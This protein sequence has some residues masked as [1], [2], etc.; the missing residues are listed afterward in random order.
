MRKKS[1]LVDFAAVIVA[2]LALLWLW[3]SMLSNLDGRFKKVNEDYDNGIAVNLSSD[4]D[5]DALSA[6]LQTNMYADNKKEAD[7]ISGVI[8]DRLKK[9]DYTYLYVLQKRKYGQVPAMMADSLGVLTKMYDESCKHLGQN[10]SYDEY[11]PTESGQGKI[12][13]RVSEQVVDSSKSSRIVK[14]FSRIFSDDVPCVGDTVRLLKHYRSWD[15]FIVAENSDTIYYKEPLL[16]VHTDTLGF[17]STDSTGVAMFEGLDTS[18]SYSVLPI[19]KGFEYGLQKGTTK[20]KLA[21]YDG[22]TAEFSFSRKEHLIPLFSNKTLS[23]IRKDKT[24]T[25]RTPEEFKS[26]VAKWLVSLLLG[27][28]IIALV[29]F[30]RRKKFEGLLVASGMFLTGL[31]VLMMFSIQDPLTDELRGVSMA[32]GVMI[33]LIV[34]FVLIFVDFEKFY[35]NRCNLPFDIPQWILCVSFKEKIANL[36]GYKKVLIF[37]LALIVQPIR[38]IFLLL[39]G[40]LRVL[41]FLF[42][43]SFKEKIEPLVRTR[44]NAS[45][46]KLKTIICWILEILCFLLLPIFLPLEIVSWLFLKPFK[47]K[48]EP[49][50]RTRNDSS[51][52]SAKKGVCVVLELFCLP[53]WIFD[54]FQ[55]YRLIYVPKLPKGI[56]W[57]FLALFITALLWVP[58]IGESVGGMKVNLNFFGLSFQPSEIAKYFIMFSIAAFFAINADNIIT[59]SRRAKTLGNKI[60]SLMWVIIGL[61]VL[62]LLYIGLGDMGPGLVIAVTFILLYSI[63]ISKVDL[64]NTDED[65]KWKRIFTCDFAM[66]VYG[67]LSFAGFIFLGKLLSIPLYFA[68]LWFAVW[69]GFGI[70]YR[71]QFFETAL[72]MNLII[73]IFVFGGEVMNTIPG[74]KGRDTAERFEKRT[75]MCKNPWGDLDIEHSGQNANPVSN[76]QVANGLWG[77]ASGGIGGQGLAKGSPNTIPAYHTDMILS[78]IGEQLGWFGLFALVIAL[79]IMIWRIMWIGHGSCHPFTFY[80]CMGF[81]IVISVQFFIIALGSSGMIPLTG[82]TVPFLSYGSVSMIL[83]ITAVGIVLSISQRQ[84]QNE[85]SAMSGNSDIRRKNVE[86]Y[87]YPIAI[88]SLVFIVMAFSTLMVWQFYQ[89]W[90]GS[91]TIVHPVYVLSKSGDPLV[92]YNPRINILMKEMLAGNIYDRNGVLLATSNKNDLDIDSYVEKYGLDKEVLEKMTKRRFSRYYPFGEHLFF[93][94]GDINNDIY[95][96]YNENTPVGYMAEAQHLSYLRGFD[97]KYLDESGK[98]VKLTRLTTK[99]LKDNPYL[100]CRTDTASPIMLRDYSYLANYL[101]YGVDGEVLK[102]HNEKVKNGKYDLH[103]TIDAKLQYDLQNSIAEYVNKNSNLNNNNL[104][105]ISVVVLDAEEGDMLASANYPLPDYDRLLKE[106]NLARKAGKRFATY[107]DNYKDKKWNA[108]TDRDLGTTYPTYPGSTAKVMSAMAGFMKL[109]TAAESVTY[110]ITNEEAIEIGKNGPIEPTID[111]PTL[112][113]RHDP[114]NMKHAIVESS[115]CY[116]VNLV[117]DKDLYESLGEIYESVGVAI[118]SYIPYFFTEKTDTLWKDKFNDKISENRTV[119]L[120]KYRNYRDDVAKGKRKKMGAAEWK[121]AWG[122][123]YEGFEL[124]ATPLNMARVASAVVNG[125]K[126]RKTEY[127]MGENGYEKENRSDDDVNLLPKSE[128]KILKEYMLAE[129]ANQFARN[130]VN[131]PS[132]VGGKT[133]TPERGYILKSKKE[134]RR[135]DTIT[136]YYDEKNKTWTR[137]VPTRNDGWYIFFVEGD[138]EHNSLA[139]AI[140]MERLLGG[141]GSGQAVRLANNVVIKELEKNKY[142]KNE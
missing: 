63:V 138:A 141:Q 24:I 128:A 22:G 1:F 26:Q 16:V 100:E 11:K 81:A 122:Q 7:F 49:L 61:V 18:A 87:G 88:I 132:Y 90:N 31:S 80:L 28:W 91:N 130:K 27:W 25:V 106:E 45:E 134:K 103:L 96:T 117:N 47:E 46:K 43:K 136:K 118:G 30:V 32:S 17:K 123:G 84:Y 21:K 9:M 120:A 121:W 74:L 14:S 92:E 10:N 50:V 93:M 34:A 51:A 42:K 37:L 94:L 104:L 54:I 77:L 58:G 113:H 140:R 53:F 98:P 133:G 75:E 72:L 57:F 99:K 6:V 60:K 5:K 8:V 78:S 79:G 4:T 111:N 135:T 116:F 69:I 33:G 129:A 142:I 19:R 125:G 68:I 56:G 89:L 102:E 119:A 20:G 39:K 112:H 29:L 115:N 62:M 86:Q 71:K 66:L 48:I 2:T 110:R 40:L 76:T 3:H 114:V 109:G 82:I 108:Y 23:Q 55:L 85:G 137:K 13:V 97:N 36:S 12:I 139:V 124:Q 105:R 64:E 73:F 35:Q 41:Q 126:L 65:G 101:I 131:L 15:K 95:F 83:N 44:N 127:L 38:W 67:V 59:Y 52:S 107:S 70:L